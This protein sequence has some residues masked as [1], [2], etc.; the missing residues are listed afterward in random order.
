MSSDSKSSADSPSVHRSQYI[1]NVI[2]NIETKT[3]C[4]RW[5]GPTMNLSSQSCGAW[6]PRKH[7]KS[8]PI[9]KRYNNAAGTLP[10]V[11]CRLRLPMTNRCCTIHAYR[12]D[13]TLVHQELLASP[14]RVI[15]QIAMSHDRGKSDPNLH[16]HDQTEVSTMAI[17]SSSTL[18]P[19]SG[20]T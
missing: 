1:R 18:S 14:H 12:T 8:L 11:E 20:T 17:C 3:L 2:S 15:S 6:I 10:S 5:T 4:K 16:S 7:F 13:T 9:V 19:R